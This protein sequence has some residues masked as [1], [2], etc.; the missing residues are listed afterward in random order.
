MSYINYYNNRQQYILDN[1]LII[2]KNE[3]WIKIIFPNIINNNIFGCDKSKEFDVT[4]VSDEYLYNI[5]L[6][7]FDE[8]KKFPYVSPSMK[9]FEN[10]FENNIN[11]SN[12][13]IYIK[14]DKT[15]NKKHLC[16]IFN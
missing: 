13:Y 9:I 6:I 12:N 16:K 4:E 2:E 7:K 1:F 15:I 10:I 11:F 3:K 5:F 14:T 8:D